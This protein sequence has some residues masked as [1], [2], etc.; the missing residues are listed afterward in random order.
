MSKRDLDKLEFT[1]VRLSSVWERGDEKDCP[2]DSGFVIRWGCK[3]VGF[4]EFAFAKKGDKV[5]CDNEC[6][7]REFVLAVFKAW[8]DT[9]EFD[10]EHVDGKWVHQQRDFEEE[11]TE[12]SEEDRQ[13]IVDAIREGRTE[14]PEEANDPEVWP[15]KPDGTA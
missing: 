15:R 11:P 1:S 14:W 3:G 8:L 9:V 7:S 10:W 2:W 12:A 6:M 13:K 4:G 5:Y